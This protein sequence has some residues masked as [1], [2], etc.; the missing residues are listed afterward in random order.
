MAIFT[1]VIHEHGASFHL[2]RSSS[3]SFF[4]YVLTDKCIL[5]KKAQNTQNK[6]H[7]SYKAQ[8]EG[9]DASVLLRRENKIIMGDRR[10][11]A[12]ER[13]RKSEVKSGERQAWKKMA[14]STEGQ[15][16]EWRYITVGDGE[17]WGGH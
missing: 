2:L 1:L 5:G 7:R 8:E 11:E 16:I 17:L 9:V 3:I 15:E 6:T 10:R 14:R 4:R 13:E 12:P